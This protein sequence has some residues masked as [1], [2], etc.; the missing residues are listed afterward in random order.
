MK[1]K[2]IIAGCLL[3][4]IL[5][6]CA[7]SSSK[8]QHIGSWEAMV[9]NNQKLSWTF[10]DKT[11]IS[12]TGYVSFTNTYTIDYTKTPICIDLIFPNST[13]KCIMK[14]QNDDTFKIAGVKSMN[15]RPTSFE[16]AKDTLVF[17]R[18]K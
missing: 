1:K 14:F 2:Y 9:L 10:D 6:G 12:K 3:S 15:S 7:K 4:I 11:L 5:C 18:K 17:K 8:K 16:N 13:V